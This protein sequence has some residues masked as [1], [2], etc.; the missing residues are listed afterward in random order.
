MNQ[1][2]A[3]TG[4]TRFIGK[5]II[6]NLLARGFHVRAL[7]RTARATSTIISPGWRFCWKIHI[8]QRTGCRDQAWSIAPA[9]A[10][11]EILPAA[12]LTAACA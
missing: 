10:Q 6:D 8:A 3:V 9:R 12:T 1:T 5:H 4:A 11:E 2:V 7:A